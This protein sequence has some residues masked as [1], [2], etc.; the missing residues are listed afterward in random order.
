M[1]P[2]EAQKRLKAA[3]GEE[4]PRERLANAQSP[5]QVP[6]EDLLAVLM[7]TGAEGCNV[8]ETAQRLLAAFGNDIS[9]IVG[10]HW[11]TLRNDIARYNAEHK[12]AKIL[13]LGKVKL[14]E[15]SAAF[16]LA[17]RAIE[18]QDELKEERQSVVGDRTSKVVQIF[19]QAIRTCDQESVYV[20][21]VDGANHPLGKPLHITTGT[22]TRTLAEPK[23]VFREAIR[24]GAHS[25]FVAHSHPNGNPAPSQ[26]DYELT[27]R[28]V[29]TGKMLNVPL[30]DHIVIGLHGTGT[31]GK[32]FVS[33]RATGK[34]EF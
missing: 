2:T 4:M 20:L 26:E 1:K 22:D 28:L 11:R 33:I 6:L 15:L 19:R 34:V 21:P 7:R 32:G 5:D 14:L 12:E 23:D 9:R 31:N 24:W 27:R 30:L 13:G 16:E 29:T 8:K 3:L 25:I 18:R 10:I 17:R